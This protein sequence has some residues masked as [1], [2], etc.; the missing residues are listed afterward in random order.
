M[1]LNER[2]K[3]AKRAGSVRQRFN[4]MISHK[5]A[6]HIVWAY[7]HGSVRNQVWHRHMLDLGE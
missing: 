5:R 3:L 6:L 4:C 2:L 7:R 1:T